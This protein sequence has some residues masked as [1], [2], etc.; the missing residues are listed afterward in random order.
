MKK[1]HYKLPIIFFAIIL[2]ASC[3][4]SELEIQEEKQKMA[5]QNQHELTTLNKKSITD[6]ATKY[7]AVSG[8]D[9]LHLWTYHFQEMFIDSSKLI[10]FIGG[11]EDITK[12]DSFYI[13]RVHYINQYVEINYNSDKNY[14]AEIAVNRQQLQHIRD[15]IIS[16]I[17]SNEGSFIFRVSKII[18]ATPEIKSD[19]EFN[20][21]KSYP[22]PDQ[23]FDENLIIFKG[24][25]VDC[26]LNE[27]L[28]D[29]DD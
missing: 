29:S 4:K 12:I 24:V 9:T 20:G 25:F 8:W 23:D 16:K 26:Y 14:I 15:L 3:G 2:L 5:D 27:I 10:N 17:H 21:E 28:K 11:I 6:L 18:S 7:K 22:Y 1:N 13:L 19:F